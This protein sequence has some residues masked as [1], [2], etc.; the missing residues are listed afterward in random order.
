MD[1]SGVKEYWGSP[2]KHGEGIVKPVLGSDAA[3]MEDKNIKWP[4][5]PPGMTPALAKAME[6]ELKVEDANDRF[7][8]LHDEM[9]GLR[10]EV[11]AL[12]RVLV[13]V[14]QHRD[15]AN[16][17][18]LDAQKVLD[19]LEPGDGIRFFRDPT[20]RMKIMRATYKASDDFEVRL[21]KLEIK[22]DAFLRAVRGEAD[23]D[24]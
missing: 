13:D 8:T 15:P 4:S 24:Y 9:M 10:G 7:D 2:Q 3:A 17:L 19:L 12:R 22:L 1:M 14:M 11:D 5:P 20:G 23:N 21:T 6:I 18:V 16:K